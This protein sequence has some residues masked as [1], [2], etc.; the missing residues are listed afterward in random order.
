M[1]NLIKQSI[2]KAQVG[3][4]IDKNNKEVPVYKTF[5]KEAIMDICCHPDELIQPNDQVQG[6]GAIFEVLNIED[7]RPSRG[8]YPFF[9]F[10]P[11]WQRCRVKLIEAIQ[12]PKP[13]LQE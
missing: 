7:Q 10:H 9:T 4:E 13:R 6:Q 5:V 2:H 1:V 8:S 3:T 12:L 11:M